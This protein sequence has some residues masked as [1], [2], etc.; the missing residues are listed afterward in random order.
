MAATTLVQ[1]SVVDEVRQTLLSLDP[2]AQLVLF[3]SRAREQQHGI[4]AFADSDW[5][6]LVLTSNKVTEAW[7]REFMHHLELKTDAVIS[8][9]VYA[10][11]EWPAYQHTPLYKNI[12]KEGIPVAM[13][14][15]KNAIIQYRLE[16][17]NETL[18]EAQ[19]MADN[20]HWNATVDRL[21]YACFYSV[22]ALLISH[23]H[24][25]HTHSGAKNAFHQH[26]VKTGQVPLEL[27]RF[28]DLLFNQRQSGDY[29][30]FKT[31]DESAASWL[32]IARKFVAA[33]E[34]LIVAR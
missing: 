24:Q 16:R 33:V 23:D 1:T 19:L 10:R 2:R 6:F 34:K 5:D 21:Y 27:S 15:D 17:A 4:P 26:F 20:D 18:Q 32:P 3:G 14:Y 8:T 9:V 7:I 13:N 25:T 28:Y 12:S 31:F 29:G 30:D 22:H 11:S